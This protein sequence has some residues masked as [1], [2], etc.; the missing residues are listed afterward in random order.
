M[1][2][3]QQQDSGKNRLRTEWKR[4]LLFWLPWLLLV[5]ALFYAMHNYFEYREQQLEKRLERL[6]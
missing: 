3:L 4:M 2:A 1:A 5:T 6:L